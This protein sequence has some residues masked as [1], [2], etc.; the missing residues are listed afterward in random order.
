[1]SVFIVGAGGFQGK[2]TSPHNIPLIDAPT[3]KP[4]ISITQ[5]TNVDQ[6]RKQR[7]NISIWL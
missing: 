3:R 4:D 2:R 1:M 5:Q 6:V 7:L